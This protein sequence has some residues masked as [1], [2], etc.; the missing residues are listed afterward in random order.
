MIPEFVT[1]E[2]CPY[3]VLPSGIHPATLEDV[4]ERFA[5]NQ[6]RRRLLTGFIRG[7]EILFKAGCPYLFLD[8]SYVTEK[9]QPGDYEVVW[10]PIGVNADLLTDTE[11]LFF[12]GEARQNQKKTYFGEY[13]PTDLTEGGSGKLFVE[14]FQNETFTGEKKGILR[15]EN[16]L[17]NKNQVNSHD[18]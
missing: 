1:I 14:F 15:I 10:H 6:K 16:W 11:L 13:F 7:A 18:N 3:R 17:K 12:S 5:V 8:G 4:R 9:E 2:G